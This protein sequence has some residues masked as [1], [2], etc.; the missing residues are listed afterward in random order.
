M[1]KENLQKLEKEY[2]SCQLCPELCENRIQVVFG[3]GKPDSSVLLLGE[4]PGL[5][6]S[7]QG[8][9]FCGASGK[10]L[11]KLL[12]HIGLTRDDVFITNTV[13]CRPP[14][15]RNPKAAEI[16]N[17]RSRLEETIKI[18]KPKV[19]VTIGN[20]AT[21]A[22]IGQA[23]ITQIRG[24][25]FD[26]DLGGMMVKVVPVVHP[27]NLLY[28]GHSPVILAQMQKDFETIGS[29]IDKV[30]LSKRIVQKGLGDY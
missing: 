6:E 22:I 4:A 28:N 18:M 13:I 2:K 9:P 25:L 20:F 30:G 8:I 7:Q 11:A 10:I 17:C 14:N 21:K 1:K 3:G 24:K 12:G 23:G 16:K 26:I 5:N 15:N 19:I 29:V 27:A